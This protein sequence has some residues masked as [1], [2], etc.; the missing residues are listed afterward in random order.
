MSVAGRTS[1]TRAPGPASAPSR[2]PRGPAAI[3]S[4]IA[5]PRPAP[6]PV[7]P[8]SAR[9]KRSK[10]CGD[11]PVGEPRAVVAHRDAQ[12]FG[13]PARGQTTRPRRR[14]AGRCPRDWSAPARGAGDPRSRP[15]P[16]GLHDDLTAAAGGAGAVSAG[17]GS[18]SAATFTRSGRIGRPPSSLWESTSRSSARRHRRSV[19]S[20]PERS[21]ARSS[22]AL[23][24][25]S[26]AT[27]ISA[28]EDRERRAQLVARV[29]H[30]PAL[31]RHRRLL[32]GPCPVKAVEHGVQRHA[33]AADLVVHSA[34]R[35]ARPGVSVISSARRRIASTGRSAAPDTK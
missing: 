5:R 29:G 8:V 35:E 14:G 33:E 9:L 1:S 25:A 19:S 11:E 32:R 6:P 34:A 28:L 18:S 23:R 10:A 27:S 22:S 31:L 12:A 20:P 17:H 16:W 3:A 15:A 24:S 30:E 13:P 26:S 7:R 2:C 21:A 4:T